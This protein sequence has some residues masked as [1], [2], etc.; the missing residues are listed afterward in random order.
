MFDVR[1]I[2]ACLAMGGAFLVAGCG[3]DKSV[4]APSGAA[5]SLVSTATALSFNGTASVSARIL[6]AQGAAA[7]DGTLVTFSTTLG[8]VAPVEVPTA[9][10][11]AMTTFTAGPASGTAV[12]TANSGSVGGGGVRIAIGVAAVARVQVTATPPVI[13]FGGGTSVIAALA[14]DA[15]N[16]PLVGI[17]VTFSTTAAGASVSPTTLKTDPK[18]IAQSTLTSSRPATVTVTAAAAPSDPG[19]GAVGPIQGTAIV[20]IG[21]QPVPVVTVTP[22]PA[23]MALMPATF[24]IGA[25][26]A[27]GSNTTIANVSVAFGDNTSANLG[28]VSGPAISVQH[29]YATGGSYTV[30]VTATDSA[31]GATTAAAVIAVGFQPPAGVKIVAD[32][33]VPVPP[34][35]PMP[36]T[37]G[38]SLVTL[39]ATLVPPT[40][41]GTQFV[42]TFGDSSVPSTVTTTLNQ[43]Q[44][45]YARGGTYTVKVDV[46]VIGSSQVISGTAI[47]VVH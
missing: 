36:S 26:P 47:I 43:A 28:A 41:V 31:G 33:I 2:F 45:E 3:G 16:N 23:P 7:P 19:F 27:P 18:G 35:P 24:V 25:V 37:P 22:P 38:T 21:P 32:P 9:G 40:L 14:V 11:V 30:S 8:A 44:H 39:T 13:P 12:V 10:G 42:W 15:N 6:T 29:V 1:S 20:A 46:T 4:L 34:L 17:P 5:L